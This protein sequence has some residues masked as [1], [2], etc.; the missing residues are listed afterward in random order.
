M[1]VETRER[2]LRL[3]RGGDPARHPE[4]REVNRR[5]V[6]M[7]WI[8]TGFLTFAGLLM[9]LS[10][11]SISAYAQFG[12]GFFFFR[13]Q[14]IYAVV[15][16]AAMRLT[17]RIPYTRWRRF[18]GFLLVATIGL[19]VV[20][21]LPGTGPDAYG[22][23][24]WIALGPVTIQP[25]ELAK[26]TLT[27]YAAAILAKQRDRIGDLAGVL[28]LL[29][30]S[31][32][33]GGLVMLQPDLG[34]TIV[35][36]VTLF[37]MAFVAGARLSHLGGAGLLGLVSGAG[38]IWFEPYRRDRLLAFLHPWDDTAGKSYQLVQGL[39]ALGSGGIKGVGLGASRQKWLYVPN[40]HTDFIFAIIGEELGLVGALT[41]LLALGILVVG[42]VRAAMRAPDPFSR[43]LASGIVAW[44]GIQ[45]IV[46]LGAV[47]GVLPITGVPLPFVSYGGS[48]LVVSL[49]AVGILANIARAGIGRASRAERPA[50]RADR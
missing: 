27:I 11:S 2:H 17:S 35:I 46:N 4:N 43:L 23:S 34:T 45:S 41:M 40:A 15:G 1:A 30:I 31:V 25:S 32:L 29:G 16:V 5:I 18:A 8:S 48:A 14:L 37:L 7:L 6:V 47:T 19:L 26:L 10:A 36:V 21:L 22:A 50:T 39:I 28:P 20:V 42:G 13:R 24:R 38:L 49:A 9:V 44:L 3:V 12:S 33:I